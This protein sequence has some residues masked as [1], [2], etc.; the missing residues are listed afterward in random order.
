MNFY[1]VLATPTL[2]LTATCALALTPVASV[3]EPS[4]LMLMMLGVVGIGLVKGRRDK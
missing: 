4:S 3:P 1:A 2:A